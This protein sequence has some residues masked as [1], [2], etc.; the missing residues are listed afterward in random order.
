[1]EGIRHTDHKDQA[2][3]SHSLSTQGNECYLL[4][5]TLRLTWELKQLIA[6]SETRFLAENTQ[7][8]REPTQE[9]SVGSD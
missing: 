5:Y 6:F 7:G 8:R 3:F 9:V 4:P 1:M 2:M